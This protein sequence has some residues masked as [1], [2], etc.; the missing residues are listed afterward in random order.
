MKKKLIIG[1]IISE[2]YH[3]EPSAIIQG[4]IQQA[5][6]AKTDVIILNTFSEPG[7]CSAE[8]W[9]NEPYIFSLAES[10]SFDGFIYFRSSFKNKE[11]IERI[12]RVLINSQK[13]VL[14]IGEEKHKYF[15]TTAMHDFEAYEMLAEHLITVHN[16]KRIYC[17]T[18]PKKIMQAEERLQGYFSAMKKHGLYY[19]KDWYEYGDFWTNAPVAFADRIISGELEK[20]DAV[21]CGN[22]IMAIA[23][24]DTLNAAGIRV[25]EDIAVTG[26]DGY[27]KSKLTTIRKN[28]SQYGAEAFRRLYH[29]MTGKR[30]KKTQD[31]F[32]DMLIG[33]TCGCP[34]SV[35]WDKKSH[36]Q[37]M[38]EKYEEILV[39]SAMMFDI[40]RSDSI[41]ELLVS[42]KQYLYLIYC[43]KRFRIFLSDS[44]L[45]YLDGK[46][47]ALNFESSKLTEMFDC[48]MGN[49]NSNSCRNELTDIPQY[50][51]ESNKL[52]VAYFL[53]PLHFNDNFFGVAALS[54]GKKSMSYGRS[55]INFISSIEA[56]MEQLRLKTSVNRSM[57]QSGMPNQKLLKKLQLIHNEMAESPEQKWTVAR[58]CGELNISRSYLQ[59]M[60]KE[61]FGKT[62][63][64]ELNALRLEKAKKFL[65][66]TDLPAADIA[67]KCGFSTYSFFV[68]KFR[69][70]FG[71]S[72]A[73]FRKS[74]KSVEKQDIL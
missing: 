53:S 72:P 12:D 50:I 9:K 69:D 64:E 66:E 62:I 57:H 59:R 47:T 41:D 15:D 6:A 56:A 46:N 52:P 22:D 21:M 5:F 70:T 44:Y 2:C 7:N 29:S 11:L 19:D 17:L 65:L 24:I 28:D 26:V 67:E 3:Y 43:V 4:I 49:E 63:F 27:E 37:I 25:P 60:F 74:F 33:T 51:S 32:N 71:A 55:Y 18:G 36:T 34:P 54:F 42:L 30:C 14:D 35:S 58:I 38:Q 31:K 10:R 8:H 61:Y 73:K 45:E 23:L 1:V 20:P 39:K 48:V 16:Y 13:P 40:M 68:Q